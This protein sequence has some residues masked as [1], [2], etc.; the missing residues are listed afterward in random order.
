MR[1]P[2]TILLWTMPAIDFGSE[3]RVEQGATVAIRR[4]AMP[5]LIAACLVAAATFFMSFWPVG[6][7]SAQAIVSGPVGHSAPA[8]WQRFAQQAPDPTRPL[9]HDPSGAAQAVL[10]EEDVFDPQG[11]RELERIEFP[12]DLAANF[13]FTVRHEFLSTCQV[14]R[15]PCWPKRQN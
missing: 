12:E 5:I 9:P 14:R 3:K 15:G 8:P 6:R 7:V 1:S 10:Y 4:V 11:R 2:R 13:S